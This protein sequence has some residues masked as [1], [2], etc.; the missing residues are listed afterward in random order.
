MINNVDDDV[1]INDSDNKDKPRPYCR[2]YFPLQRVVALLHYNGN[3]FSF[4]QQDKSIS[5]CVKKKKWSR[6]TAGDIKK[7]ERKDGLYGN[8]KTLATRMFISCS[9]LVD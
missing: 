2:I 1:P 4:P 8:E 3:A 6:N 5:I 9:P 7:K